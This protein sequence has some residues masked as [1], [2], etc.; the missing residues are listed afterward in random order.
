MTRYRLRGGTMDIVSLSKNG[1]SA[2][3][4]ARAVLRQFRSRLEESDALT[5]D[6]RSTQGRLARSN[7]TKALLSHARYVSGADA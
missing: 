5:G 6:M 4:A 7:F 2:L 1:F 3:A